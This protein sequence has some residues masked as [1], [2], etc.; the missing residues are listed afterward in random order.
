MLGLA[1]GKHVER[2]PL[3]CRCPRWRSRCCRDSRSPL[4][5][6]PPAGNGAAG[7]VRAD[8][9]PPHRHADADDGVHP[10]QRPL[11]RLPP[12]LLR[13]RWSLWPLARVLAALVLELVPA[14]QPA[15][16][17]VDDTAPA[18]GQAGLRQGASPRPAALPAHAQRLGL[19]AP[20]GRAGGQR[21]VPL[22]R[23]PPWALPVLCRPCT[24]P[25]RSTK[26]RA[27]PSNRRSRW[28]ATWWRHLA[29]ITG[30]PA[31]SCWATGT[32]PATASARFYRGHRR[33]LT[34]VSLFHPRAHL[35]QPPPPRPKGQMGRRRVP[36]AKLPRPGGRRGRDGQPAAASTVTWYGGKRR[37]VRRQPAVVPGRGQGGTARTS[38]S[39]RPPSGRRR[40]PQVGQ[41][42]LEDLAQRQTKSARPQRLPA[43]GGIRLTDCEDG[44]GVGVD[45]E[46]S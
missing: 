27:G 21:P 45:D 22:L 13:P 33:R 7:R 43:I 20:V 25:G 3:C 9:R 38:S 44:G 16:C 15:V 17:A 14:D 1:K 31:S 30:P 42:P 11:R 18:P 35:C 46:W 34:L 39:R 5:S 19:G 4:P 10:D 8:R 37:R 32:T 24:A 40:H 23:P 41:L 28:P 2:S 12:R 36:G 29:L 26:R 6:R